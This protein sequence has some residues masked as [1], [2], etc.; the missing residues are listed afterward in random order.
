MNL[1]I[2]KLKITSFRNITE[3]EIDF[4]DGITEIQAENGKGKTNTLSAIMWCLFGKNIYEAKSFPISPIIEGE[5]RNDIRT[6]VTIYLNDNY[7]VSRTYYKRTTSLQTGYL[8]DGVEQLVETTQTNYK[9]DFA[10]KFVDEETFKSLSNINYIPSLHWKELKQLI[11]DLIGG[12]SDEEVLVND[13]FNL[14]EEQIRL[15]G[16]NGTQEA[17]KL[18]DG[19]LNDQIKAKET[20]YQTLNNTKEKYV[21]EN[22][23]AELLK[24]RKKLLEKQIKENQQIIEE[25]KK[26]QQQEFD[27]ENFIKN[28]TQELIQTRQYL[29]YSKINIEKLSKQYDLLATDVDIIRQKEISYIQSNI[30]SL[31]DRNESLANN[32]VRYGEE[33]SELKS[34]GEKL[35]NQEI[36]VENDKCSTCGQ[37]LP[38]EL[39]NATL[40]RLKE[41]Q[42]NELTSIKNQYDDTKIVIEKN[43]L[44]IDDNNIK[45]EELKKQLEVVKTKVIKVEEEN[46]RQKAVRVEKEKLELELKDVE[47]TIEKLKEKL[48]EAI[49]ISIIGVK[50]EVPDLTETL[51]ELNSINEQLATTI[52]L[53]KIN[54][55]IEKAN[56]ELSQ[57]KSNK[58]TIKDKLQQVV[59]FNNIKAELL[60]NKAKSNFKIADFKTKEFTQDGSEVETFKIC[61]DGIDYQE[62]NTGMKIMVAIDLITGIQKLKDIYVPIICDNLEN[63]TSD[64]CVENTQMIVAR[65]VK[66]VEKLEVK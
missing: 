35:K 22:S 42:L 36:K 33:L 24:T 53:E 48:E 59:K 10:E 62:L 51:T 7:V 29:E 31:I 65:A 15:M 28:R 60:R 25:N 38:E 43:Q 61:V 34:K 17:L 64:I 12:V 16:I 45:I 56:E 27:K 3:L 8:I 55:D 20:E 44:E 52:T 23:N 54:S 32:N 2:N 40:E 6:N 5:E 30:E 47:N 19:L 41:K 4:K 39:I 58:N 18:S 21:A 13:D 37:V 46:E 14:I 1:K 66:G 57:L 26:I 63:V 9:K 11:F 49:N 50:K